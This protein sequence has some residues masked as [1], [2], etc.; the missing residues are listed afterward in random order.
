[1]SEKLFQVAKK[2]KTY[3]TIFSLVWLLLV[4]V[5][6]KQKLDDRFLP[7]FKVLLVPQTPANVN[8]LHLFT[9]AAWTVASDSAPGAQE[10]RQVPPYPPCLSLVMSSDICVD[11]GMTQ[12][13]LPQI[14]FHINMRQTCGS[15]CVLEA[16]SQCGGT[17]A[18]EHLRDEIGWKVIT[19]WGHHLWVNLG[20]V[21]GDP[22]VKKE[23]PDHSGTLSK[24]SLFCRKHF[25][26]LLLCHVMMGPRGPHQ[27]L[28]D[29]DAGL[30]LSA[31]RCEAD[32][33][34]TAP[35]LRYFVTATENRPMHYISGRYFPQESAI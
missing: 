8:L 10:G 25:P 30:G 9:A 26:F 1:M 2:V 20:V 18:V 15:F 14:C 24:W 6:W 21:S 27:Q 22:A 23:L 11:L 13:S 33:P 16:W 5:K 34:Y 32:K 29:G 19:S 4:M 12:G 3:S 17:K 35:S 28:S 7:P 31:S